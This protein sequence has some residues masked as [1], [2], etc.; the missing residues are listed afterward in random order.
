[1]TAAVSQSYTPALYPGSSFS[2]YHPPN[3][4]G[5]GPGMY[6][7]SCPPLPT[8]G[9]PTVLATLGGHYNNVNS[10]GIMS[11]VS[12]DLH[13]VLSPQ[14][15]RALL[16]CHLY[17]HSSKKFPSIL[18]NH[19]PSPQDSPPPSNPRSSISSPPRN[20]TISPIPD[21]SHSLT[22]ASLRNLNGLPDCHKLPLYGMTSTAVNGLVHQTWQPSPS[23]PLFNPHPYTTSPAPLSF[24]PISSH[25][26]TP[27]PVVT[28]TSLQFPPLPLW[29]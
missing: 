10:Q 27:A 22:P 16:P 8:P 4:Y 11:P 17:L 25:E 20:T 15:P 19:H 24:P 21:S 9:V 29:K 2:Q 26:Y 18:Q 5:Y 7:H 1:M 14:S 12:A 6:T 13:E 28:T 23:A 3:T